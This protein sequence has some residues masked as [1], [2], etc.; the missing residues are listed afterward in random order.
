[1]SH[2]TPRLVTALSLIRDT[3]AALGTASRALQPLFCS[4][5]ARFLNVDG[6]IWYVRALGLASS[7]FQVLFLAMAY[8]TGTRCT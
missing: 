8:W 3:L 6:R 5:P 7:L 2:V 4:T 1:M